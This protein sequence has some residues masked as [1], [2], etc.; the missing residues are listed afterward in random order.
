[1]THWTHAGEHLPWLR[2]QGFHIAAAG[3]ERLVE[4]TLSDV[5]FVVTRGNSA[6]AWSRYLAVVEALDLPPTAAN[7]LDALADS[8]RDLP[9]NWAGT[10]RLALLWTGADSL[11]TT[12]LWAFTQAAAVLQSATAD[13]WSRGLVFETVAFVDGY[14]ADHPAA[15]E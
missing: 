15:C 8:L 7:N 3:T 13:C 10:T 1:V 2:G 5:G 11:L 4:Q 6:T 14:G 12:D 9:E